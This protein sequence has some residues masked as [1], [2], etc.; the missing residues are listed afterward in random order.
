[1]PHRPTEEAPGDRSRMKGKARPEPRLVFSQK[2]QEREPW[3]MWNAHL[4][5]L[6]SGTEEVCLAG[7]DRFLKLLAVGKVAPSTLYNVA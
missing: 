7:R 5:L 2:R 1:M 4:P 3:Q 6:L